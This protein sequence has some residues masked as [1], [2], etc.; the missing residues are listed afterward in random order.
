MAPRTLVVLCE[1][2]AEWPVMAVQRSFSRKSPMT[3]N[4]RKRS[5]NL[6]N[7]NMYLSIASFKSF[8]LTPQPLVA[9]IARKQHLRSQV[10]YP[11]DSPFATVRGSAED[12]K[13]RAARSLALRQLHRKC[14]F[15]A[16]CGRLDIQ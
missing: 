9:L 5:K 10:I 8:V 6:T 13:L 11:H 16:N 12:R 3:G 1:S 15:D 14:K 4:G 2:S 7:N